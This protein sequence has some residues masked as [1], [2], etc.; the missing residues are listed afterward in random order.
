[1]TATM[2]V[3]NTVVPKAKQT[4]YA[5]RW[6]NGELKAMKKEVMKKGRSA[7]SLCFNPEHPAHEEYRVARNKYADAICSAK[8]QHWTEWLESLDEASVW[9]AR[10]YANNELTDASRAKV[11]NLKGKFRGSDT[12]VEGT[13]NAEKSR[14]FYETFYLEKPRQDSKAPAHT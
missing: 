11:P 13:T 2:D 9:T 6:W 3:I 8:L 4:P 1:M 12:A 10:K 5:K 7:Y 14:M